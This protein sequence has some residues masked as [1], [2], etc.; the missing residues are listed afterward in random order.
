MDSMYN[1]TPENR[2][3]FFA[4]NPLIL[5]T[6]V[7]IVSIVVRIMYFEPELPLTVDSLK[8]FFYAMDTSLL[9]HLPENY[10]I[11]NNGWPAFVSIFFS[12]FSFADVISY[13]Q[14]QR[15]LAIIISASTIVPVYLLCRRYFEPKYSLVGAAIIGFEPRLVQNSLLGVSDSL[16]ILLVAIC[17]YLILSSNKKFIFLAFVV[18]SAA[19]IVRSEGLFLFAAISIVFL[20]LN[21]KDRLVIPKYAIAIGIFL[22]ILLPMVFYKIDVMGND[23]IFMRVS[24]T[25]SNA[26]KPPEE[27]GGFSGLPLVLRG[28]ENFPKYLGWDMIPV[29]IFFVPIGFLLILKKID[30]K[31]MIPIISCVVM[32]IPTFYV[33]SIPLPDTR[34]FFYIYP[35]FCVISLFTIDRF[36]NRFKAQNMILVLIV[37]GILFSSLVF[38]SYKVDNQYEKDAL[39]VAIFI[40]KTARGVNDFS[41]ESRYLQVVDLPDD[42]NSFKSLFFSERKDRV[43][44]FDTIHHKVSVFPTKDYDTLEKFIDGSRDNGLTHLVIDLDKARQPF[45]DDVF[46]HEED[47]TYL[48]KEFDFDNQD[49]RYKVKVFRINYDAFDDFKNTK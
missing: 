26:P 6:A 39:A 10:S 49:H 3:G 14:L 28:L 23:G 43:P 16:Y 11:A 36:A 19:T 46:N 5:L 7:G 32:S 42:T 8:Y 17:F 1:K 2:L 4:K 31:K 20:I 18:S 33:Y 34:Y 41:P 47:Y 37:A 44:V 15:V 40:D 24:V 21:R 22:L 48:V 27:T 30:A 35:L 13:M 25:I 38:L 45:F 12:M 29:F 9:G